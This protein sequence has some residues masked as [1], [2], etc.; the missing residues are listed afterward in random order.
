MASDN[1]SVDTYRAMVFAQTEERIKMLNEQYGE[2]YTSVHNQF[3]HLTPKE[4]AETYLGGGM[5]P[6]DS[7]E[8]SFVG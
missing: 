5:S 4:F 1:P 7:V 8:R 6:P 2:F 3:S